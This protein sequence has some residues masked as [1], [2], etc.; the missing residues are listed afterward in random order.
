MIVTP[1]AGQ[2]VCLEVT[3]T[4]ILITWGD[5]SALPG[6]VNY[7]LSIYP[8][9]VPDE[10][11]YVTRTARFSG[12]VP[13]QQYDITVLVNATQDVEMTKCQRTSKDCRKT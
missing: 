6:F 4:S 2:I 8:D 9:V 12:L 1:S 13:G 7:I 10:T 11:D 3:R 5:G